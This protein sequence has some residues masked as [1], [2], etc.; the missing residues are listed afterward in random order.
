MFKQAC[1]IF[2][3]ISSGPNQHLPQ[4][5][6]PVKIQKKRKEKNENPLGTLDIWRWQYPS[7]ELLSCFSCSPRDTVSNS[8]HCSF[9]SFRLIVAPET[10]E[11]ESSAKNIRLL[12]L[13]DLVLFKPLFIIHLY[14][15][16][17]FF[18]FFN[19]EWRYWLFSHRISLGTN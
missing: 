1:I 14:K 19:M 8:R 6:C 11:M 5:Q 15:S 17:V 18:F 13:E 3:L 12:E 10:S 16:Q 7:S 2:N 9:W 4:N